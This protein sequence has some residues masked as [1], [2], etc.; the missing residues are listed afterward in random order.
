MFLKTYNRSMKKPKQNPLVPYIYLK[1][2]IFVI[3]KNP[4]RLKRVGQIS[5]GEHKKDLN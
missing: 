3:R 1:D 5:M 4:T 2:K